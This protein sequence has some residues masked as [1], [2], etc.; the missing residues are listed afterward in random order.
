[1]DLLKKKKFDIVVIGAG[2]AG[3][4]T[5]YFSKY[6]DKDN[7]LDVLLMESLPKRKFDRYHSMCGE[8]VSNLIVKDFPNID[9][10]P[11]IKNRIDR[12]VEQWYDTLISSKLKGFVIDRPKFLHHI[13]NKFKEKGGYY[14]N[15]KFMD[16]QTKKGEE[17]KIL[18]YS[19]KVIKTKYLVFAT[20]PNP[21][22]LS[23]LSNLKTNTIKTLL[24]QVLVEE[25]P[26]EKNC[27]IF[28]Y[29]EKYKG[30]YK[31]IFPWGSYAKLGTPFDNKIE[32]PKKNIIRKDA[33]H[34]C[35]GI[36]SRYNIGNILLVGDT[37]FQ[38]NA[39]TKGGIRAAINAGKLAAKSMVLYNNPDRYSELWKKSK[40]FGK[41]YLEAYMKLSSMN[42]REISYHCKP[43]RY[44]LLSFPIIPFKYR[45]YMGLYRVYR[46]SVKYGW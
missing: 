32:L 2:P 16:M 35:C 42:N 34:V 17:I 18:T 28:F 30:E 8:V 45:K 41:V 40:F 44:P 14:L 19:G 37:A 23:F 1:M 13:I 4:S 21:P 27:I 33:K 31:W 29:D 7:E 10:H 36:L 43:L 6:F 9:V 20:G 46:L 25:Y 24:Y 15:D 38:N 3:T 26:V 12:I 11:F 5:S 22:K 39:L